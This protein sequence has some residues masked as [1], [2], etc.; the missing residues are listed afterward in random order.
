VGSAA[1]ALRLD[2]AGASGLT[3]LSRAKAARL[4]D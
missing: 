4:Q 2:T 3:A 1:S